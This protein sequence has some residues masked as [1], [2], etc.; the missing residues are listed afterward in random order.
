VQFEHHSR[1]GSEI[2]GR[3]AERLLDS[4]FGLVRLVA[5]DIA[6]RQAVQGLHV[7]GLMTAVINEAASLRLANQFYRV[8]GLAATMPLPEGAKPTLGPE[9]HE[10]LRTFLFFALG[11]LVA[12]G[13][14]QSAPLKRWREE[15]EQRGVGPAIRYLV[16]I[17]EQLFISEEL[18]PWEATKHPKGAWRNQD[19]AALRL[20]TLDETDPTQ[21]I[22]CHGLCAHHFGR[23]PNR[24][25]I[26]ADVMHLVTQSWSRLTARAFVLSNP[27]KCLPPL[28]AALDS[29]FEGW[30]EIKSILVAALDCVAMP[31]DHPARTA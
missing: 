19:V 30:A 5:A 17:F 27:R 9:Y 2:L 7:D 21:M 31:S 10:L 11:A 12:R 24:D 18:D 26:A 16:M 1:L 25:A 29:P 22:Q 13:Q 23:L 3:Y 6:F 8:G 15:A 4:P 28:Q 14:T 20:S